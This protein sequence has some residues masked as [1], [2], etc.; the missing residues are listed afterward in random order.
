ML[1]E[2]IP[3]RGRRSGE[4]PYYYPAIK[5]IVLLWPFTLRHGFSG[6][7]EADK[8]PRHRM[9]LSETSK[10]KGRAEPDGARPGRSSAGKR[11]RA[12]GAERRE[13]IQAALGQGAGCRP[14]GAPARRRG[15]SRRRHQSR[16]LCGVRCSTRGVGDGEICP[17]QL[18]AARHDLPA[19]RQALRAG[20]RPRS[21]AR[22][23][24]VPETEQRTRGRRL[25]Q[26]PSDGGG[27]PARSWRNGA[28]SRR[29]RAVPEESLKQP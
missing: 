11:P 1:D 16:L 17:G 15:R 14:L 24:V 20:A 26:V 7:C 10:P 3:T 28:V 8:A 22:P 9:M 5:I 12:T 19:L 2:L 27:G 13:R 29:R 21:I 4:H 25:R 6:I 23:A 18:Q